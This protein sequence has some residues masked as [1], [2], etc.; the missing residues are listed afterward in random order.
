MAHL[1]YRLDETKDNYPALYH[2]QD[3]PADEL[4]LRLLCDFYIKQ[5]QVYQHTWSM[6]EEET[7]VI[8]V[9]RFATEN[10][11]ATLSSPSVAG[12]IVLE[13]REFSQGQKEYP[14][15]ETKEFSLIQE[16]SPYVLAGYRTLQGQV[17][18]TSSLEVDEDRRIYVLYVKKSNTSEAQNFQ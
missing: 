15:L 5:N 1:E 4:T 18:E 16:I 8:Y 14:L 6:V 10:L 17:W 13:I 3:I 12:S 11:N 7:Y 9:T 2:Y